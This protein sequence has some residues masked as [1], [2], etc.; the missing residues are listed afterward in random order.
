MIAPPPG[1]VEL[2][3]RR[4]IGS[5]AGVAERVRVYRRGDAL[6]VDTSS[7]FRITRHRVLFE[8]VELA[9]IHKGRNWRA[10]VVC[11]LFGMLFG[12]IGAANQKAGGA[13]VSSLVLPPILFAFVGMALPGWVVSIQSRRT[14]TRMRFGVRHAKAH[15]VFEEL[16]TAVR[17]TQS[18]L[19]APPPLV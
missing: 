9:T 11:T 7:F 15:R 8:E 1:G 14:W 10:V 5:A 6:E 19:A 16:L 17:E 12:M 2:P 13:I 4:L 18:R 3:E